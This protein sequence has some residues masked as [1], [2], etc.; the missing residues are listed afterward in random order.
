MKRPYFPSKTELDYGDFVNEEDDEG[1]SSQDPP[2][3]E[4]QLFAKGN[5]V[6]QFVGDNFFLIG[7]GNP[8]WSLQSPL[9][10]KPVDFAGNLGSDEVTFSVQITQQDKATID[11]LEAKLLD[12]QEQKRKEISANGKKDDN[13][14]IKKPHL[15]SPPS[16]SLKSPPSYSL[17][18]PPSYSLKEP[19]TTG[20][21][22]SK[23]LKQPPPGSTVASTS[24]G[25][26]VC[27]M[28]GVQVE[29]SSS[30][31]I[32][33]FRGIF[34]P[35]SDSKIE[36]LFLIC[37]L[38][39]LEEEVVVPAAA[40]A[41]A[42]TT[43]PIPPVAAAAARKRHRSEE[44]DDDVG[45]D[46]NVAYQELIDLH[47][48]SRLTTEQLRAKYY[49]GGGG[50]SSEPAEESKKPAASSSTIKRAKPALEEEDD[51]DECGF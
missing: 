18:A 12:A 17:K 37:S 7:G 4:G 29:S 15:K 32:R 27:V 10:E 24:G 38:R 2:F 22:D 43:G 41:A 25:D 19:P 20:D 11:P 13:D 46:G 31:K 16:Y 14:D 36:K 9:L 44:D 3:L 28:S 30:G 6:I 42:T 35:P 48:D 21:A 23:L 49:G 50:V 1:E 39:H 33:N 26:T 5:S 51:D 8:S 45:N 40:G 34:Y 47:D